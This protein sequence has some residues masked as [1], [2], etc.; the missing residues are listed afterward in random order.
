MLLVLLQKKIALSIENGALFCADADKYD[1]LV[2]F[3]TS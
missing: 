3:K 1:G 2:Q